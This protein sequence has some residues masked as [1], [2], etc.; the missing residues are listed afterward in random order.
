MNE[1]PPSIR[2]G[3]AASGVQTN[4]RKTEQTEDRI[5][6]EPAR[7]VC[8][9]QHSPSNSTEPKL[10]REMFDFQRRQCLSEDVSNHFGGWAVDE[11][12]VTTFND[13]LN[14]VVAN[15]DMFGA[16]LVNGVY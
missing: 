11:A 1:R 15:V 9:H 7:L 16:G 5:S 10:G 14:K 12:Y 13:P 6:Q 2:K 3:R 8:L 4:N